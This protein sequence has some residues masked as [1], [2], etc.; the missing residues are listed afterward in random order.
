MSEWVRAC[1]V[2]DV[3]PEDVI[4]FDHTGRTYAIYR[5]RDDEFFASDGYCTHE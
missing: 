4:R 2:D 5:S 1:A 3:E